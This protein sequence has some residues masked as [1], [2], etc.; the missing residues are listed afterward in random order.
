MDDQRNAEKSKENA[1][2][3]YGGAVFVD[4]HVCGT[5]L[6]TGCRGAVFVWTVAYKT[7]GVVAGVGY[8]EMFLDG[9]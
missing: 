5:V 4:A 2:G 9:R 1:V 8:C 7:V 3:C 6:R